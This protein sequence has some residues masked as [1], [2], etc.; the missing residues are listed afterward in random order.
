MKKTLTHCRNDLSFQTI[1]IRETSSEI[2]DTAA[3]IT[4]NVWNLSDV[5]E[6]MTTCEEED[7]YQA[8]SC[9]KVAILNDRQK[10]WPSN[11]EE[12]KCCKYS[13]GKYN[14]SDPIDGSLDFRVGAIGKMT[15]NP[16]VNLLSR[17]R[18]TRKL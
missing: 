3:S 15:G 8:N 13:C 5:I 18:P 11:T 1:L 7:S 9:P 12:G 2:T 6:H 10:V 17:L 14:D 4:G 16:G